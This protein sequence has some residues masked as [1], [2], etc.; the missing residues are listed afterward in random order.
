MGAVVSVVLLAAELVVHTFKKAVKRQ[1]HQGSGKPLKLLV[2]HKLN[3]QV[4]FHAGTNK[5]K[6]KKI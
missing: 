1:H 6:D 4:I 3:Y 5:N 2:T